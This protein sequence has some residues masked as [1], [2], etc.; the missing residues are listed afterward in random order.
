MTAHTGLARAL[1]AAA[2]LLSA[3]LPLAAQTPA[4]GRIAVLR[5][6]DGTE[7]WVDSASVTRSGAGRYQV[8]T[9][10]QLP[11]PAAL[12]NGAAFDRNVTLES[13]DCETGR[14][15][16]QQAQVF[17]R[18]SL[19]ASGGAGQ[20]WDA[21]SADQ[22]PLFDAVC[23]ALAG[24]F[25]AALPVQ[26]ELS[27]VDEQPR[28]NN[29]PAVVRAVASLRPNGKSGVVVLHFRVG[30]DGVPEPATIT[31]ESASDPALADPGKGVAARMRF[32][33]A[34]IHGQTVPVWV[35]VPIRFGDG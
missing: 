8:R 1:L 11:A 15:W 30:A 31:V 17:L 24:S 4:A 21:V 7:V 29:A 22:R 23:R 3:P 5:E 35:T 25:A 2:L 9:V 6:A 27:T 12:E 34:R 10:I 26:P 20:G 18:D 13:L 16:Q 19:M 32:T 14:R 28:L 33:P